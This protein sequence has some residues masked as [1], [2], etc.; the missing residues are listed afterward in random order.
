MYESKTPQTLSSSPFPH[1]QGALDPSAGSVPSP[2]PGAAPLGTGRAGAA[3]QDR[4]AGAAGTGRGCGQQS[5]NFTPQNLPKLVL[6]KFP[7]WNV[8]L[9]PVWVSRGCPGPIPPVPSTPG[10]LEYQGLLLRSKK[11]AKN[12]CGRLLKAITA[13]L[14]IK[15][16]YICR[17]VRI[18]RAREWSA[19]TA[20]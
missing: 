5:W 18:L 6:I 7:L 2:A 8:T 16:I 14:P 20:H 3:P 19:C 13:D 12:P 10:P 1:S 11:L 9:T 4:R 17:N 15:L